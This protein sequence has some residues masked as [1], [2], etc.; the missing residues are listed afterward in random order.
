MCL[1]ALVRE[2]RRGAMHSITI[3]RNLCD[4]CKRCVEAC[5]NDVIRF[6]EQEEVAVVRYPEECATC[7]WCELSCPTGAAKVIPHYPV[8]VPEP[9]PK[10]FYPKS[11]VNG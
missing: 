4:G 7:N 9:Y 10:S 6:D 2:E 1:S 8:R 5:F 3:D 11:Y